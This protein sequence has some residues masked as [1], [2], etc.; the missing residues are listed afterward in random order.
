MIKDEGNP[1][2]PYPQIKKVYAEEGNAEDYADKNDM[3]GEYDVE[4]W[5]VE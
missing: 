3:Y 4:E 2:E 5:E 1:Y